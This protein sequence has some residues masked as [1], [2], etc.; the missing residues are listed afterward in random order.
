[1]IG[2]DRLDGRLQIDNY[3]IQRKCQIIAFVCHEETRTPPRHLALQAMGSSVKKSS[4]TYSN[5]APPPAILSPSPTHG[6][7][8]GSTV[9]ILRR[10]PASQQK[11]S[12]GPSISGQ[13]SLSEREE[14]YRLARERI[15]G[16]EAAAAAAGVGSANASA[17][18]SANGRSP[19]TSGKSS[20]AERNFDLVP[21]QVKRSPISREGTPGGDGGR[22][23]GG[24]GGTGSRTSSGNG[25]P[26]VAGSGGIGAG[27]NAGVGGGG[28]EKDKGV[29]RQPRGPSMGGGFGKN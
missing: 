8:P 5:N 25:G 21:T 29:L 19:V 10:D 28:R 20:P 9:K 14:E 23:M 17:S 3:G 22:G 18:A 27:A 26:R 6:S 24:M 16:K 15:F 12:P 13:K 11:K 2:L 4:L 1:M 7:I